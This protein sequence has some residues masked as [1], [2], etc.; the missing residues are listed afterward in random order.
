M[1]IPG[2]GVSGD[3]LANSGLRYSY[4]TK[5]CPFIVLEIAQFSNL[6]LQMSC[7]YI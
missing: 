7:N 2:I 1:K 3:G 6:V 5:L 4:S